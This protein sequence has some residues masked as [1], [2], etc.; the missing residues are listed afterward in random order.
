MP[1]EG[2][3]PRALAIPT[4]KDRV[5]QT[6]VALVLSP[7]FELE[8]ESVSYA[9]RPQRSV[10]KAVARI[11]ELR[12]AGFRWVVDADISAYFDTI[13]H[14]RLRQLV[15]RHVPDIRLQTLIGQWLNAPIDEGGLRTVPTQGIAQGSPLSPLL[16]NLYLDELDE[17]ILGQNLHLVRYADD[18]II[19]CREKA[20][21]EDALELTGTVLQDL[22]LGLNSDKTRIAHFSHGFRFLGKQFFNND[23]TDAHA[24][25]QTTPQPPLLQE[26]EP[27]LST[28]N[29]PD[30]SA[31]AP[32]PPAYSFRTLYLLQQGC[33]LRKDGEQ[34]C[35]TKDGATLSQ[36]PAHL[37]DLVL[38]YGHNQITTPALQFCFEHAIPVAYL[39]AQG[40]FCGVA[41][42]MDL[43]AVELQMLQVQR[44]ADVAWRLETARA[45]V[46]GKLEN[47][48]LALQRGSRHRQAD[49]HGS[50][51][52]LRDLASHTKGADTPETLNGI[53]G[54]GARE[55]FGAWAQLL[56]EGWCFEGRNRQP[57]LDPVNALLS[58]GYTLLH[59]NV[60]ALL[61]AR[62]LNPHWGAYHALRPGHAALAS[63]LMEEFR[64]LLVDRL[65]LKLIHAGTVQP[66][67]FTVS[68]AG[69]EI[70]LDARRSLIE[71]FEAQLA[72][73]IQHPD[74]GLIDWRRVI[75]GQVL[76]WTR[77]L[78]G[79]A[80][81]CRFEVR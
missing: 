23:I 16:A 27:Q 4:V 25:P 15:A 70:Q 38:I 55:Y 59:W 29:E 77:A 54:A 78:R 73:P 5:L 61:R 1:R 65:V 45:I 18:F 35:V 64:P 8:F 30:A 40:R 44:H 67:Q 51:F 41:D 53:E 71:A 69:C 42:A 75:D 52:M 48:R 49:T 6:A 28:S 60:Y 57:P 3:T 46:R 14:Q 11:A 39:T 22:K 33:Q 81:Y 63:D 79:Q 21:A 58:Y 80:A 66:G 37:L 72:S 47:S 50:E 62:G 68:K 34:L 7:I 74:G 36:I 56:P 31:A 32:E 20:R 2:K 43:R 26:S 17:A 12:D 13:D 76:L 24:L 19:L 10:Q 9:Y